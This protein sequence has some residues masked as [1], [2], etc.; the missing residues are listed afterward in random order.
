MNHDI[1]N[2]I[3]CIEKNEKICIKNEEFC[4]LKMMDFGGSGCPIVGDTA[5][6][7]RVSLKTAGPAPPPLLL[8]AARITLP[9]PTRKDGTVEVF[10]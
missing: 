10:L 1:Q 7:P 2:E 8:W 5:Y 3:L 6:Q 4:I 9:H